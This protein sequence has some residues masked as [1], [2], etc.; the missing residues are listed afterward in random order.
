MPPG[1]FAGEGTRQLFGS[2]IFGHRDVSRHT[3]RFEAAR[4]IL[5]FVLD[6]ETVQTAPCG[7]MRRFE[8]RRPTFS[9]RQYLL[10][11]WQRQHLA[12]SPKRRWPARKQCLETFGL[13]PTYFVL[14]QERPATFRAGVL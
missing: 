3:P 1:R 10:I 11:S 6:P 7:Q 5:R 13:V 4:G 8:Q 12:V 2:K 14:R 9:Q